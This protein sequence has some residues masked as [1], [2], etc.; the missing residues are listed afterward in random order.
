MRKLYHLKRKIRHFLEYIA[1]LF[2]IKI[3]Q[4]LT[5]KQ[6]ADLCSKIF[7]L[8]GPFTKLNKIAIYNMKKAFGDNFD[9][10][11]LVEGI[12]NNFG[13]FVGEF[14]HLPKITSE[15]N[16]NYVELEGF[17]IIEEYI[18]QKQPFIL[19]SAHIGNW[20]IAFNHLL[21]KLQ[22]PIA[23]IIRRANNPLT[24]ELINAH[25]HQ[26][27][28]IILIDKIF[29]LVKDLMKLVREK[30]SLIILADQK[31]NKGMK[32][33]FFGKDTNTS[34]SIAKIALRFNY[35]IIPAQIIRKQDNLIKLVI[36]PALNINISD[37]KER[38]YYEI[39]LKI[40][41]KIESWIRQNP[42]QWFWFYS[43]W[44]KYP[45]HKK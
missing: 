29:F 11:P 5:I 31:D 17:E 22:E 28:N 34:L 44:E 25:R 13:R 1:F 6:A 42:S 33:P 43:R 21:N 20:E 16:E 32:I 10:S 24:N 26:N 40:N 36:H 30:R 41:Q 4:F 12:W 27:K 38:I 2:L 37:D 7:R 8:I 19:F 15:E 45:K 23:A 14:A 3:L 39:M 35:K 9:Y 18:K